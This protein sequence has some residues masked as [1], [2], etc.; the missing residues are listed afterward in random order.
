[1]YQPSAN[2]ERLLVRFVAGDANFAAPV[3]IVLSRK[4]LNL[5]ADL[6]IATL[7]VVETL[8]PSEPAVSGGCRCGEIA[9]Y[10]K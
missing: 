4:F 8:L 7:I 10:L 3:T 9:G 6:S 1:V 2:G 5:R